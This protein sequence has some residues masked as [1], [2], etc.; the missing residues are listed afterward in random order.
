MRLLDAPRIYEGD[1]P[2]VKIYLGDDAVWPLV[3]E[4][5]NGIYYTY[6]DASG[7]PIQ[8]SSGLAYSYYEVETGVYPYWF[9]FNT[10]RGL[11]EPISNGNGK[12][13]FAGTL[14]DIR[15]SFWSIH[16]PNDIF[17]DVTY[18]TSSV[19][20]MQYAFLQ[21]Y[22][23]RSCVLPPYVT[24]LSFT[25]NHA[26]FLTGCTVPDSVTELV[27]TFDDC[28]SMEYL[29]LPSGI[30]T[31]TNAFYNTKL[32]EV[33]FRGTKDQWNA[34]T[35]TWYDDIKTDNPLLTRVACTDGDITL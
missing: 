1:H 30:T 26:W 9:Y 7:N 15:A 17:Y 33:V 29:S 2:V 12:M 22:A 14:T 3:P 23:V 4:S 6:V 20:E 11:E 31:L 28:P 32:T 5:G 18:I 35:F 27:H 8:T 25:F 19:T 10:D 24:D 34:I 21:N 16:I 13:L